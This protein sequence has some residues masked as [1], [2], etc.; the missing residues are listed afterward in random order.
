[1]KNRIVPA[2]LL[3]AALLLLPAPTRPWPEPAGAGGAAPD[4]GEWGWV[5]ITDIRLA[6]GSD[7][8]P[9][10]QFVTPDG[11]ENPDDQTVARVLF[12]APVQPGASDHLRRDFP[13]KAPRR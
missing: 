12:P 13:S 5:D 4:D 6:D 7:L 8:K 1:M 9:G 2:S 3:G 10:L 11:P